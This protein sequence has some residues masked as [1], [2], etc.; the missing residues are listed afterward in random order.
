VVATGVVTIEIVVVVAADVTSVVISGVVTIEVVV[1]EVDVISLESWSSAVPVC[2]VS[3]VVTTKDVAVV[4]RSTI[5]VA[6]VDVV[7]TFMSSSSTRPSRVATTDEVLLIG[8]MGSEDNLIDVG[9]PLNLGLSAKYKAAA[10]ATVVIV[11]S[12]ADKFVLQDEDLL[13]LSLFGTYPLSG[14]FFVIALALLS[15]TDSVMSM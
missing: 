15:S 10:M 6:V 1:V 12:P 9:E 7:F 13:L 8:G 5:V 14:C 2:N 4:V 3:G 11:P